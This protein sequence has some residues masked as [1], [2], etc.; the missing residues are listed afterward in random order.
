MGLTSSS[1]GTKLLNDD[2]KELKNKCKYTIAIGRKS[3]CR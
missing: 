1:T 3:K 2:L